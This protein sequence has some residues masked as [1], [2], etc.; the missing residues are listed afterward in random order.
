MNGPRVS[1]L[2]PCYRH[3]R[4][5][6]DY[7]ESLLAQSYRDVELIFQDDAS[8]DGSWRVAEGYRERLQE[9]LAR[10]VLRR[11]DRNQGLLATL[12]ALAGE[13]TGDVV[14][15]LESDDYLY[16]SKIEEN[17]AYLHAHPE[18]GLVHSDVDFLG[19]G[20]EDSRHA[21]WGSADRA[22]PEGEVFED[23]LYEN[24]I[25]TCTVAC[26]ASLFAAHADFRAYRDRGYR[27]ADYPMFL[28]LSRHTRFGYVDRPLAVYRVVAGSIS[29]PESEV[30]RLRWK[31]DYYRIKRDYVERYGCRETI[32]RRAERQLHRSLM[33]LGW[34]A[35][36]AETFDEGYAWLLE[37]EPGE[38]SRPAHRVRRAALRNGVLWRAVRGLEA[39]RRRSSTR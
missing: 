36:S 15:L 1:V 34:A 3:E 2:T 32:R 25:L 22:I 19:E 18:V 11:S 9:R 39:L 26:R 16:P 14:C 17:V 38:A 24:F 29:H 27:T 30:D 20:K 10:V 23:L 28:D 35:G 21:R 33:Q 4:Y 12:E 7:F 37:Q 13:V 6:E 31:L 5:L 8:P